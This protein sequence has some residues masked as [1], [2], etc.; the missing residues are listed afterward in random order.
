MIQTA[1][2]NNQAPKDKPGPIA[3]LFKVIA[4]VILGFWYLLLFAM[5]L[6]TLEYAPIGT[7]LVSILS[8]ASIYLIWKKWRKSVS[9]LRMAGLFALFFSIGIAIVNKLSEGSPAYQAYQQES[10]RIAA[11]QEA[12][13]QQERIQSGNATT[14]DLATLP[15]AQRLEATVRNTLGDKLRTIEIK[16]D[17]SGKRYVVFVAYNVGMAVNDQALKFDIRHTITE[18]MM[19]VYRLGIPINRIKVV[20]WGPTLDNYGNE[21]QSPI[22]NATLDGIEGDKINWQMEGDAA[23][24]MDIVPHHWEAGGVLSRE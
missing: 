6:G 16:A 5:I 1:H 12:A 21:S 2:S 3:L 13:N 17:P 8:L 19:N 10:D 11:Q 18:V 23:A 9:I 24:L 20:A 14:E 7:F 22:Y 15:P 4:I